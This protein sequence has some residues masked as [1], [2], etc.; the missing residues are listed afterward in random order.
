MDRNDEFSYDMDKYAEEY[1]VWFML[2]V[3]DKDIL[4]IM[5]F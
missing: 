4:M 1:E 2:Q 5:H 3:M